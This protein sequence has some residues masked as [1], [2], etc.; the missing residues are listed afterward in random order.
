MGKFHFLSRPLQIVTWLQS[1]RWIWQ[2]TTEI[3]VLVM[4][5]MM[6]YLK[7]NMDFVDTSKGSRVD[8]YAGLGEINSY[9]SSLV[10][11]SAAI[12][13]DLLVFLIPPGKPYTQFEKMFMMFQAEVWLAIGV[14]FAMILTLIQVINLMSTRIRNIFNGNDI[15]SPALNF[16]SVFFFGAQHRVPRNDFARC[17]LILFIVWTLIIRTCYQSTLYKLLQLD[18]RRPRFESID[19]LVENNFTLYSVPFDKDFSLDTEGMEK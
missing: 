14:T 19:Q 17:I 3:V 9:M 11:L 2:T 13:S 12:S 1:D 6:K 16:I 10:P 5:E 4:E 15:R 18:L 7:S 8:F